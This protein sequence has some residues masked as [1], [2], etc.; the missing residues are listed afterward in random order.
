MTQKTLLFIP[1]ITFTLFFSSLAH[2]N[3]NSKR[4][5]YAAKGGYL[6]ASKDLIEKK[7]ASVHYVEINGETALLA[8]CKKGNYPMTQFLIE[9]RSHIN[10]RD[11]TGVSCMHIASKRNN[12]KLLELLISTAGRVNINNND[13]V[14]PLHE[15]AA[16]GNFGVV[17]FLISKGAN[18]KA[19]TTRAWLPLHHAA[20]F[21]HTRVASI[22]LQRG[23]PM[24]LRTSE[25]KTVFDL[26]KIA[27]DPV[28]LK[29]LSDYAKRSR[30]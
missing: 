19:S 7:G 2:A 22:L 27:K 11:K 3:E 13:G 4:L 5:Y 23:T 25:G 8:A 12:I 24:Y 16:I 1:I 28:M 26:A 9:K 14:T 29:F 17:Q 20:R 30:Q 10:A 18:I 21:G 6:Q 15:A